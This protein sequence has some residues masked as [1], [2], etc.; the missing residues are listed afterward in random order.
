MVWLMLLRVST[1]MKPVGDI[2]RAARAQRNV[3]SAGSRMPYHACM[4]EN[5]NA[6]STTARHQ[7]DQSEDELESMK[8][9]SCEK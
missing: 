6:R 2:A 3:S 7:S 1:G 4:R 9:Y 8:M 5:P